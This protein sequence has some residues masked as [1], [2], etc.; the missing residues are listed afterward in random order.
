MATIQQQS[1]IN[2]LA[3]LGEVRTLENNLGAVEKDI[4]TVMDLLT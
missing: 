1:R 4:G 3:L 2:R